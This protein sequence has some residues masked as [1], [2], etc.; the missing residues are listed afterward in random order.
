MNEAVLLI[1]HMD[2]ART[3]ALKAVAE[4]FGIRTVSVGD[5]E[6]SVP[7]GL[8]ARA[9]DPMK[10]IRESALR[11]GRNGKTA[12]MDEEM[13]VMAGFQEQTFRSF[14]SALKEAGLMIGLKAVLTDENRFWSG[15][16]LQTEL[17]AERSAIQAMK[18]R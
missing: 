4:T 6:G 17:K 8:L 1:Y 3:A 13:I 9:G 2:E 14:L 10:I 12:A 11:S 15:E 16:M 18:E 7:L 5:A